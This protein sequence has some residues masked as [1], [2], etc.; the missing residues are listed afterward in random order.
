MTAKSKKNG[1]LDKINIVGEGFDDLSERYVK[2][3][4][5]GYDGQLPPYP[6]HL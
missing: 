4:V 1:P 5:Q 3:S 2:L 6:A